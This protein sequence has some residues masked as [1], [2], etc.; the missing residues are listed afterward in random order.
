[1]KIFLRA[2]GVAACI[3]FAVSAQAQPQTEVRTKDGRTFFA[4]KMEIQGGSLIIHENAKPPITIPLSELA[5]VGAACGSPAQA[6]AASVNDGGT[7]FGI[8]GSNTIG[9]ALMPALLRKYG[10]GLPDGSVDVKFTSQADEQTITLKAGAGATAVID[11]AAHG[12]ATAFQDLLSGTA[13]IGMASRRIKAEEA[14]A[15]QA[16]YARI[17]S[18]P[19]AST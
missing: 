10:E 2:I 12:S 3:G 11:F 4:D 8:H 16:K 7:R 1:M 19:K 9:A 18:P 15:L 13:A 6:A 17:C 14:S 5:C